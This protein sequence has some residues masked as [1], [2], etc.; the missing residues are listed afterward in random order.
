MPTNKHRENDGVKK[1]HHCTLKLVWW[2]TDIYI[3]QCDSLQITYKGEHRNSA[4]D[5]P[6]VTKWS[7]LISSTLAQTFWYDE[8]RRTQQCMSSIPAKNTQ[9][10]FNQEKILQKCRLK[11]TL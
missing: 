2:G 8:L 7:K 9:L 5:T 1:N 11:N 6:E 3:D 4:V 10:E